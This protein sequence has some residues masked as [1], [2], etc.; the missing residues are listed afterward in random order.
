MDADPN[1]L[2][3]VIVIANIIIIK[4]KKRKRERRSVEQD[5]SRL[6]TTMPWLCL[7]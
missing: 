7:I 6:H 2:N 5:I 3:L 1:V 4:K